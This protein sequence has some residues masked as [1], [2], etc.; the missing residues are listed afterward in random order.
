M[1]II[2]TLVTINTCTQIY[3]GQNVIYKKIFSIGMGLAIICSSTL[4][5]LAT[6]ENRYTKKCKAF[7]T[8]MASTIGAGFVG[9]ES[10]QCWDHLKNKMDH[11]MTLGEAW[12]GPELLKEYPDLDLQASSCSPELTTQLVT[13]IKTILSNTKDYPGKSIQDAVLHEDLPVYMVL[14]MAF[15][16]LIGCSLAST[17]YFYC[18]STDEQEIQETD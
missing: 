5:A 13:S 12:I 17:I 18:E 10:T 3:Q 14:T 15:W 8:A 16:T 2:L 1:S 4:P 11:A 9:Y 6:Q 7:W